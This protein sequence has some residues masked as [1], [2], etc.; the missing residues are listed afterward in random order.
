M[1]TSVAGI[2]CLCSL[3]SKDRDFSGKDSMKKAAGHMELTT[4]D[5]QNWRKYENGSPAKTGAAVFNSPF[6]YLL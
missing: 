5:S 3:Y 1:P 6:T 2:S 4:A